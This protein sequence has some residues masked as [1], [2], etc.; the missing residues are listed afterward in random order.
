MGAFGMIQLEDPLSIRRPGGLVT[1]QLFVLMLDAT[2][3]RLHPS[4]GCSQSSFSQFMTILS[5]HLKKTC[6]LDAQQSIKPI[7][8]GHNESL[9]G[10]IL[11]LH[12]SGGFIRSIRI[13]QTPDQP[14]CTNPINPLVHTNLSHFH[15]VENISK[16]KTSCTLSCS[17]EPRWQ[18]PAPHSSRTK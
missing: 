8:C 1:P 9:F 3:S 10:R 18:D 4:N 13:L 6:S 16:Q 2:S 12:S 7:T 5:H 11:S 14:S 17:R 15:H